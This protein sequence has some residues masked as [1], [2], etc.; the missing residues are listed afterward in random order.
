MRH[1][2]GYFDHVWG[3]HPIADVAGKASREIEIIQFT[4]RQTIVEGVAQ[5]LPLP[6]FLQPLNLLASQWRLLRLLRGMIKEQK[7]DVIYATDAYY[8]GLFGLILK[9]MTGQPL[10]VAVFANQDALYE[11][12]GALAMPRLLPFR[13]LE[14]WVARQVLSR[15]DLVV[16]GLTFDETLQPTLLTPN[17][18]G[19]VANVA[20]TVTGTGRVDWTE[21]GITSTGSRSG[22]TG[23]RG[24]SS[25]RVRAKDADTIAFWKT[26]LPDCGTGGTDPCI[27]YSVWTQK[28]TEIKG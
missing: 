19:V 25:G 11:A 6:R 5:S 3:V 27:D 26:P 21:S 28:W 1:S 8:S 2:G 4:D 16:A 22:L 12:T 14:Q 17:A 9:R 24:H 20:G 23:H 7:I 10:V 13:F 15:A 18:L